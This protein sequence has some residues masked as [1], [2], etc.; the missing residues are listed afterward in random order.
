MRPAAANSSR[1]RRGRK[2]S[3]SRVW[4]AAL[5][6]A[7]GSVE[8]SGRR[9]RSGRRVD[10]HEALLA[11][12]GCGRDQPDPAPVERLCE[13]CEWHVLVACPP[14]GGSVAP[15]QV[16]L[17]RLV[18]V[19]DVDSWCGIELAHVTPVSRAASF[20]RAC[21]QLLTGDLLVTA[22]DRLMMTLPAR[23]NLRLREPEITE[24]G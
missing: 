22:L 21:F 18:D 6:H 1:L 20:I 17:A 11:R 16:I 19:A 7:R 15:R 23:P 24:S 3:T 4:V 9:R 10:L 2:D 14:V 5:C 12:K 13:R 8:E